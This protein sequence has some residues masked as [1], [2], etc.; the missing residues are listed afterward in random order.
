M[1]PPA[2][3]VTAAFG[4]LTPIAFLALPL[5]FMELPVVIIVVAITLARQRHDRSRAYRGHLPPRSGQAG[6]AVEA[7]R[8]GAPALTRL[9]PGPAPARP[10]RI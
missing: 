4:H 9:L 3:F 7:G 2:P 10:A 8:H 1:I 6:R 5:L